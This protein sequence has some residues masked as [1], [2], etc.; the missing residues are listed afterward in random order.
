[1]SKVD[2]TMRSRGS[3]FLF[4]SIFFF[5]LSFAF[6]AG[7][8]KGEQGRAEESRGQ[9]PRLTPISIK[10]ETLYV[11]IVDTPETMSR[12]LMYRKEL[13]RNRG[14]LFVYEEERRLSFWMANTSIPLSIAF[15]SAG[16]MIVD[17]QDMAPFDRTSH[18]SAGPALYA[19]EVNQGW[20][21]DKGVNVGDRVEW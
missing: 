14:M 7:C 12:G 1:M 6:Y 13:E 2:Y 11:E 9:G 5:L 17:I 18:V 16:G 3:T 21:R 15:I 20:F 10:G 19:L 8:S 4:I